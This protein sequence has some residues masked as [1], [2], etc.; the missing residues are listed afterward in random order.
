MGIFKKSLTAVAF[1]STCGDGNIASQWSKKLNL[2]KSQHFSEFFRTLQNY[3]PEIKRESFVNT[4]KFYAVTPA[5]CLG[6][7]LHG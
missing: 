6:I 2:L 4:G 1:Q 5:Y 7:C 3:L